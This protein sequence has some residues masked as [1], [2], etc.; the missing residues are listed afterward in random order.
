MEL[1]NEYIWNYKFSFF[2][3]LYLL[4]PT[5]NN[6][7]DTSIVHTTSH[8]IIFIQF[9]LQP[10]DKSCLFIQVFASSIH[11]SEVDHGLLWEL[12]PLGSPVMLFCL[13]Y[14]THDILRP[15]VHYLHVDISQWGRVVYSGPDEMTFNTYF[16]FY[17]FP[18]S[19]RLFYVHGM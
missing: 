11:V 15:V 8:Y 18:N 19:S 1:W 14:S 2:P 13:S 9:L 3:N 5:P 17:Y 12:L 10:Q 7:L 16:E 6:N 4:T